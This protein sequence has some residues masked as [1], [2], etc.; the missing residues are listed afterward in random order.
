MLGISIKKLYEFSPFKED[1]LD[2]SFFD[3]SPKQSCRSKEDVEKDITL[4]E[5]KETLKGCK[6]SSP[7]PDGITYSIY[8]EFWDI[9][10]KYIVD[11]WN[12]SLR[13]GSLPPSHKESV[14]TLLPKPGKDLREIKNWRPI[15]LTNCD[16]KIIT[17]A[18]A[19]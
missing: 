7:G 10:G 2:G 18:L 16:A 1:D 4:E 15:T 13:T 19:V 12:H 8:K 3:Y 17:K 11:S 5:L 14:L 6:D 9:V